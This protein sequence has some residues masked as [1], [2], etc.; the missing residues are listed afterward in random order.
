MSGPLLRAGVLLF[1]RFVNLSKI[2]LALGFWWSLNA[3][4]IAQS[5]KLKI[6]PSEFDFG[7][8]SNSQ[9]LQ[10]TFLLSNVGTATLYIRDVG[11]T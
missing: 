3:E 4:A 6:D 1:N 9:I 11:S 8:V 10:H 7:K 5:A 2:F